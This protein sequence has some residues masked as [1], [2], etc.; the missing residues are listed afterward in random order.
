MSNLETDFGIPSDLS[1]SEDDLNDK[2]HYELSLL[3][4]FK[5]KQLI[6]H[7]AQNA[8]KQG[9]K[10]RSIEVI[11]KNTFDGLVAEY[12]LRQE[13]DFVFDPRDW[14]D[15][16]HLNGYDLEVKTFSSVQ[17]KY[18]TILKIDG[19]KTKYPHVV[20]FYRQGKHYTLDAYLEY[21]DVEEKYNIVKEY[22]AVQ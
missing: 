9:K 3:A 13:F 19:M 4:P 11:T 7:E 6:K 15:L 22:G 18:D 17:Q 14:H 2:S 5:A 12:Y 21:D 16:V 10:P 20:M 1:F 8:K